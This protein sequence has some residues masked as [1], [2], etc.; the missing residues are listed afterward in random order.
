MRSKEMQKIAVRKL[1]GLSL[2][3]QLVLFALMVSLI[4]L[5]VIAVRDTFQ[6]R[7][8]LTNAAEA[9]L[10]TSSEQTAN[11]VDTF[12]QSTLDSVSSE[13]AYVDFAT[14][15]GLST[16]A[17]PV[18][19]ARAQDLL[20]HLR[21]KSNQFIISYGLVDPDGT[22][23]LDTE[24]INVGNIEEN[25]SYFA[26]ARSSSKPIVS[27]VSYADDNKTTFITFAQAITDINGNFLGILRVKYNAAIF[28]DLIAKN[29][30]NNTDATILLLDPLHIRIADSLHP[31][32]I[33][34][35][36]VPLTANDYATAISTHRFLPNVP[37]DQQATNYSDLELGLWNASNTPFFNADITPET[38][39]DDTVSVAFLKT[40]PWV[41]VY[42]RPTSSFLADAQ[43]QTRTNII[44]VVLV[45]ILIV[46]IATFVVR[47]L[48]KPILALTKVAESISQGDLSA[49]AYITSTDE[50]GLLASTFNTM[51]NQIQELVAGLEQRVAQRTAELENITKQSEERADELQTITE[52]ARYISTEKDMEKLL[53]LITKTVSDRFGYYHV[54]VFLL[55]ENRR[56][57]VLRAANSPG[58]QVMLKRQ[59]KLEVGQVGIVGNVT[60]TG[61][62]RIA[63]DTGADA[64]Y[65][66]NPDLPDTRSE[67]ALPLIARGTIIGALD[68]QSVIPNAFTDS[69]ISILGL[70]ADQLAIAIDNVRLLAETQN[71]LAEAQTLFQ[72]YLADAWQKKSAAEILGYYQ[73]L[74]G[75]QLITDGTAGKVDFPNGHGEDT[76][77][78]P[79]QLRN[80]V[81]G[82]LN[83]R[84]NRKGRAW[85]EEEISIVQAVA[86]RLGLA[87]DNAR[88]F[89]ET[90]AR[91]S[92]ERTVAEITTKIRNTNNPQEIVETA[93]QELQRVLGATRVE[94]IP[95]KAAPPTEK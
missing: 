72:N 66:N 12:I 30:G 55:D 89:E 47:N 25:E 76:L 58:G 52:I 18:L 64:V 10:K 86:E 59:H 51:S 37:A 15:L 33:Q 32:L 88:L 42:S 46:G 38:P 4:P 68:V 54:G 14:Y 17:P 49:R 28:Q 84:P 69:D 36:I 82:T 21:D 20:I 93:I 29:A 87:L 2:Q 48:T 9:S 91:A 71:A 90:S 85:T 83:I 56:Y 81:I 80:Q 61:T 39:G 77:A 8:A 70:L 95:Q 1:S 35:S 57:A 50:I 23:L 41:V 13:A 3:T 45:S 65:F 6:T 26:K 74:T 19:K 63:L 78:M 60:S 27:P 43:S 44:F 7:Q 16:T 5:V 94:L 92:R 11:S 31:E 73:T 67:M 40:Q 22:V 53:P 79:I 62:P 24:A 75:G 34:K